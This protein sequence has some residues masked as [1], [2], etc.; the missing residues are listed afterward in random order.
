M[1]KELVMYTRSFGC[2]YVSVAKR[3]LQQRE[4][5]YREVLID[6]DREARQRVLDWTGY[7]SVPTLIVSDNGDNLPVNEP[8]PL[9]QGASPRGI[10]R[11]AMITEPSSEQLTAWLQKHDLIDSLAAA[12]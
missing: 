3:V 12:T 5:P 2:P 10:D 6:K 1:P 11:G 8:A 9:P 7:L 4:V